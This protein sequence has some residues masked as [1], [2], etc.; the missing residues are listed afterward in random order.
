MARC[1]QLDTEIMDVVKLA[2]Q[3]IRIN[4]I[5]G[6]VHNEGI[7]GEARLANWLE[8]FLDKY[9]VQTNLIPVI[10]N[11]PNL[12]ARHRQFNPGLPT[13]AFEA[14]LD[15]VSVE[16]MSIDPFAAEISDGRLYGRGAC[17]VKGT[18]AVMLTAML[19]WFKGHP[20]DPGSFNLIFM[21]TMGEEG[22]T[23]GARELSRRPIP[24]NM[25]LIGEPTGMQPVIGHF[26]SWRFAVK[27][28]GKSCHS[29]RPQLGINA[30]ERISPALELV[31]HELK[32]NFERIPGNAMSMTKIHGGELINIV[33]NAC[34]L[35]VDC[36]FKPE[37][38]ITGHR[39][40]AAAKL[41][42]LEGVSYNEIAIF[43]PFSA[44]ADS[45]ILLLLEQ[46]LNSH[47][48]EHERK[49]EPWYS[50]AGHFSDAGY[51]TVLWGVGDMA[52]AHSENEYIEIEQ[53]YKGVQVLASMLQNCADYYQS[54][55]RP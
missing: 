45:Q 14:H 30:I 37:T 51:D 8:E 40:R 15:T 21:A 54:K 44:K 50:D 47:N 43:P 39:D 11:R 49:F 32:P 34:E 38:D 1:V 55:T 18:M 33:P 4:S 48:L 25:V 2:Q 6:C 5:P 41:S 42:A 26:G 10:D 27:T 46:A 35:S 16:G 29:S 3:L 53:L 31:L 22:G 12:I 13:L 23:L 7:S 19:H 52:Q 20:F 24:L 17:D 9:N 36:R 28:T